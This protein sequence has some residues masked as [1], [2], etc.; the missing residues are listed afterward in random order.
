MHMKLQ[1]FEQNAVCFAITHS[2]LVVLVNKTFMV[3]KNMESIGIAQ[4]YLIRE[5][6]TI[7]ALVTIFEDYFY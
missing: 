7:T 4:I 2:L 5:M 1:V 6:L 3:V